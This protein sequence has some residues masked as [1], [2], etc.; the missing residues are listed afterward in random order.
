MESPD[1][2]PALP[3]AVSNFM[4]ERSES[5]WSS[6]QAYLPPFTASDSNLFDAVEALTGTKPTLGGPSGTGP[7]F[8]GGEEQA[9]KRLHH[10]LSDSTRQGTSKSVSHALNNLGGA[11]SI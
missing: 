7:I 2:L 6:L 8:E 5:A 4:Q 9:W 10:F 11:M 1:S 3:E